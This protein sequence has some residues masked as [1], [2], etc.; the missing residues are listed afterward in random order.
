MYQTL[1]VLGPEH[2]FSVANDEMRAL[3][4]VDKIIKDF[5]GHVVNFVKQPEFHFRKRAANACF[6]KG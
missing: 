3:P 2:E 4:I 1:D 6:G 5:H